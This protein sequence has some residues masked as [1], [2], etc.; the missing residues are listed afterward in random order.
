MLRRDALGPVRFDQPDEAQLVDVG[1][2]RGGRVEQQHAVRPV[3][4]E[5]V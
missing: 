3:R 5:N 1:V 4:G 2:R